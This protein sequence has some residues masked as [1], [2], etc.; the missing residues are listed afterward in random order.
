MRQVNRGILFLLVPCV[1]LLVATIGC[2]RIDE[3]TPTPTPLLHAATPSPA[4]PT[5]TSVP[6]TPT[7]T[8]LPECEIGM[9]LEPGAGC[10]YRNNYSTNFDLRILANGDATIDGAVSGRRLSSWAV[11]PEEE[12]CICDLKTENDGLARI[13]RELPLPPF[14][15]A[16][17]QSQPRE[18][19]RED[20]AG[21]MTLLPGEICRVPRTY[22]FFDVTVDGLGHLAMYSDAERIE[23]QDV[24]LGDKTIDFVAV[25]SDGRWRIE[26]VRSGS[27]G[28]Q[29]EDW[30]ECVADSRVVEL[31]LETERGRTSAVQRLLAEGVD[32]NGRNETGHTPLFAAVVYENV[33]TARILL[34]AG[35]DVS[36]RDW[37]GDPVIWDAIYNRHRRMVEV[38]IEA[39]ADVNQPN[40][41]GS[42]PLQYAIQVEDTEKAQLLLDNGAD[43]NQLA[44]AGT[45]LLSWAFDSPTM[46]RFLIDAGADVNARNWRGTPLIVDAVRHD[47]AEPLSMLLNAGADPDGGS[48]N[49]KSPLWYAAELQSA[50]KVQL[51]LAA[52]AEVSACDSNGLT[53]LGYAIEA[54]NSEIV[55]LLVD[56]GADVNDFVS[57]GQSLLELARQVSSP[58]IV[59][60]LINAG[61]EA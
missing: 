44:W 27:T 28:P 6:P 26:S 8:P 34:D 32:V 29:S 5:A 55:R 16:G 52:G 40:G 13:I 46:S 11:E 12:L 49:R 33:M 42:P 47:S 14:G 21:N 36:K 2:T 43:V 59:Q 57:G 54:N 50:E 31:V 22:C 37:N 25:A 23:L 10:T 45:I 20:C 15:S 38:L 56:A 4:L 58:E 51:L 1:F 39:G 48:G 7:P 19:D 18:P 3:V 9:R 35:A 53:L 61:A 24:D 41:N 30:S 60:Y 17:N